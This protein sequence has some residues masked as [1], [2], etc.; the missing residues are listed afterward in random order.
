MNPDTTGTLFLPPQSSTIAGDV[1]ALFNFVLYASVVFFLIVVLGAAY[2]VFR[3]R[4]RGKSDQLDTAPSH[5]TKLEL[6]WTIIPVILVF[7]VFFWG[8]KVFLKMHVVPKDAIEIKVTAQKWF[9]SFDYVKEDVNSL[10]ELVV[11]VDMPVQLTMSSTDVIHS[12]YVPGFR[13][14]LDVLP[15]R[16]TVTWFEATDVGSYDLFCT[17]Y[18]GT[19]HSE[20][21]GKVKVVTDS[22]YREWIDNAGLG[23]EEVPLVELGAK[24]Y[25]AKACL[26][27][28]SV[29]G[30]PMIGPS[31]KGRFG[32][33]QKMDDGPTVTVDEN[34][35]RES[36]LE[37]NAKH[38]AGFQPVMPSYQGLLKDREIDAVIEYIK[39]LEE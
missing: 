4:K 25:R 11:P 6:A 33:Q 34:Y 27:C 31:F 14:K 28:H 35:L 29:D 8:F 26:T 17:E 16:Y 2:F 1:D 13:I 21:I 3:Y 37:P 9:W 36:I 12:F 38:A 30:N 20:M 7:T 15:N 24:V 10:N 23:G 39:S 19:G 18:C 22:E 32:T 5:S